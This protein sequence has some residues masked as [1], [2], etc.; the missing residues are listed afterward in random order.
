MKR[1]LS[2]KNL[3]R[4][5][6]AAV[7]F[8]LVM[9][10]AD[11]PA[12]CASVSFSPINPTNGNIRT[13]TE[14]VD[15]PTDVSFDFAL[16]TDVDTLKIIKADET[17]LSDLDAFLAY[18]NIEG[19]LVSVTSPDISTGEVTFAGNYRGD[20]VPDLVP[21]TYKLKLL[22]YDSL[23]P[24]TLKASEDITITIRRYSA[25]AGPANLPINSAGDVS[26]G[27]TFFEN[28]PNRASDVTGTLPVIDIVPIAQAP[29]DSLPWNGLTISVSAADKR[30][31]V[32]GR[33]ER[34]A[35]SPIYN[36]KATVTDP[37]SLSCEILFAFQVNVTSATEAELER[38][39]FVPDDP[40]F[41]YPTGVNLTGKTI[42]FT[43]EP[44]YFN[45]DNYALTVLP[46]TWRGA[47]FGP[48]RVNASAALPVIRVEVAGTLSA[49]GEE[50]FKLVA[51]KKTDGSEVTADF[52]V[53]ASPYS[54]NGNAFKPSD[55]IKIELDGHGRSSLATGELNYIH[56]P[57]AGSI[58]DITVICRDPWGSPVTL[59]D[60][61]G[62]PYSNADSGFYAFESSSS[63]EVWFIP[64]S[65]GA[66]TFDIYYK[67]SDGQFHQE[68]RTLP[69]DN[70]G[71]GAG[72]AGCETG[73]GFVAIALAALAAA[74]LR[75]R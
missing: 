46:S 44:R 15:L 28:L 64:A 5:P 72:G 56:F 60:Y 37:L 68:S 54:L 22:G 14:N 7:I 43:P 3:T 1:I 59:T 34:E 32:S 41:E 35:M 12:A 36:L 18:V 53:K 71:D 65:R 74:T 4:L 25:E 47:T 30:I 50:D 69:S 48:A 26:Y 13:F 27:I 63:M 16:P 61:D 33:P 10:L 9:T 57:F 38:L 52:H 23:D 62:R 51:T 20:S 66:Y 45:F 17:D 55:S 31:N 39:Y 70:A 49:A 58:S 8:A 24:S 75:K 2:L 11:A 42:D 40:T 73:A 6:L 29:W 19:L 21:Y 67:G